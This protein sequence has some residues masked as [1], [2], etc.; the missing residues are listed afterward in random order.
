MPQCVMAHSVVAIAACFAKL[1]E[2]DILASLATRAL[3]PC[4]VV[5]VEDRV[6][7][8]QRILSLRPTA[9]LCP[10]QNVE[11]FDSTPLIAR[12]RSDAPDRRHQPCHSSAQTNSNARTSYGQ[13]TDP[14]ARSNFGNGKYPWPPPPHDAAGAESNLCSRQFESCQPLVRRGSFAGGMESLLRILPSSF[15]MV[16]PE[17]SPIE[18]LWPIHQLVGHSA[19]HVTAQYLSAIILA[20]RA[21]AEGST[22]R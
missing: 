6:G 5:F 2:Y 8:M 20:C 14:Q 1:P 3:L 13:F 21:T 10:P 17:W 9:V 4:G 12:I 22:I 11:G 7:L 15:F 18:R 16:A 19:H